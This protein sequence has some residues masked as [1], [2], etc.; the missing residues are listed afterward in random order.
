M[1]LLTGAMG[2][3][4]REILTQ[5]ARA[6]LPIRAFDHHRTDPAFT[7]AKPPATL[8]HVHGDLLDHDTCRRACRGVDVVIHTAARQYHSG[9]PRWHMDEFFTANVVM[10]HNLV[11]AAVDAGA[12]HLVLVS[13]DMVYGLPP[14]RPDPDTASPRPRP[15]RE[16]DPCHPVGPYGRSK[17][18][19][20]Q[21]AR[22]AEA[23]GLGLTVLRPRL[24][25]GPGRLGVLRRLFDRIRRGARVPLIG[26]GRNRYQMVA[27]S[28][29]AAA[30]LLA[31]TG[32]VAGTFNLGSSDPPSVRE[33]LLEL[34]RR[35]GSSSRLLPTPA[36]LMHAALWALH[37]LRAAPLVPEQFRIASVDYVLDTAAA[38][39][40][41]GWQ[42][43]FSDVDMLW[44][45]YAA[46]TGTPVDLPDLRASESAGISPA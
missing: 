42:P 29:V 43:Q 20:E 34:I 30:C 45:A 38:R 37:A 26:D 11:T 3:V 44:A 14:V 31:A 27:V 32:R 21:I 33:L 40:I 1:I 13:S 19:S 22:A 9:V 39:S 46:Y 17:L 35:A 28:D 24:I 4:G 16:D 12:R 15:V 7:L 5:A 41:L 8:E 25:I 2:L 18:E 6:A 23:G 10:T 36:G